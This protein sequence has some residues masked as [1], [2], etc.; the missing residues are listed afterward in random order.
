[1][2]SL[3]DEYPEFVNRIYAKLD[4][5][6]DGR[7]RGIL[8][9]LSHKFLNAYLK[10]MIRLKMFHSL[11]IYKHVI[12]SSNSIKQNYVDFFITDLKKEDFEHYSFE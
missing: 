4:E 9:S 6:K 8:N 12:K 3:L 7:S 1:M 2:Y 11:S 10:H 5:E